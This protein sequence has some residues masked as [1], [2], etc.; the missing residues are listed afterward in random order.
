APRHARQALVRGRVAAGQTGGATDEVAGAFPSQAGLQLPQ[1][2]RVSFDR[3]DRNGGPAGW[4]HLH[5]GARTRVREGHR[6]TR[7]LVAALPV[8]VASPTGRL[9]RRG[10]EETEP[11]TRQPLPRHPQPGRAVA[12]ALEV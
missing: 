10:R 8:V 2:L 1:R 11:A 4:C 3:D 9:S 6:V 7:V 5:R 12:I